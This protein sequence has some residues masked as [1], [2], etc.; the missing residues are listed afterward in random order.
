MIK[1]SRH[2]ITVSEFSKNEI[3]K[4]FGIDKNKISVVY[5][6][7]DQQFR[8]KKENNYEQYI[9]GVSSVAYHKNFIKLI[10]AFS[11]LN[12]NDIKLYIVGGLN[13]KIFGKN[14]LK[15]LE[16]AKNN[17]N[18]IFLGRV[19]DEKLIELYS[20]A[21]C[22]VYP[23]LYEGFGIPPLEAQACGC[24]IVV[25]D[26][27]VFKEIYAD[28]AVYFNPLDPND[29]SCK[30]NNILNDS[31][32]RKILTQKGLENAKKFTWDNSAKQ[33]FSILEGV[34]KERIN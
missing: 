24:P 8:P 11:L 13:E 33:F 3:A 5:N 29:I 21:I 9:L 15:I 25:S 30:I 10:E 12:R 20:N 32:L 2:I 31:N 23:S 1:N 26:I 22:F 6:G 18:I 7:V 34:V 17:D 14:S 28:S 16:Y 27:P 19:D 4:Y